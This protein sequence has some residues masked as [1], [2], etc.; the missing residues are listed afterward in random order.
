MYTV[1]A[2]V[3]TPMVADVPNMKLCSSDPLSE[4]LLLLSFRMRHKAPFGVPY[5][6]P[7]WAI[8][9]LCF[10]KDVEELEKKTKENTEKSE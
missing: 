5:L 10:K 2:G 6:W 7:L 9:A 1:A 3:T 4:D 8:L